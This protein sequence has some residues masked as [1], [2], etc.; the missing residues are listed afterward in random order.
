MVYARAPFHSNLWLLDLN[1][2]DHRSKPLARQ[3][4]SGTSYI[5]RPR[6]SP[7]GTRVVFTVGH[8]PRTELYT[9]PLAG[10]VWTQ[11]TK[12]DSTNVG[13]AW[14]P[15]GRQIAFAS[16]SGQKPQVWT[17]DARG[18]IP[19]RRSTGIVSDSFDV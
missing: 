11:L 2:S 13:A 15:D 18:G 3:L 5:E 8:E 1:Q 12:L 19:R 7:D 17:V 4:T 6:I 9:M 16:T 10:G 14:S